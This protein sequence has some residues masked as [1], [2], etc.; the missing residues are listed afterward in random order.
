M[1][2]YNGHKKKTNRIEPTAVA[3]GPS[4]FIIFEKNLN[5]IGSS[6]VSVSLLRPLPT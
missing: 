1:N 2:N 5:L 4:V 3:V 6:A